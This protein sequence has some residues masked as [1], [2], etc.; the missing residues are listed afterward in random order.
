M[1]IIN[2]ITTEDGDILQIKPEV[3]IVGLISLYNFVDTTVGESETDYYSKEFRYSVNGGITF[4]SWL[5]L[6]TINIS[7]VDIK[8]QDQFVIEY[9]YTHIGG[10]PS[11]NLE[12]D[13][14]LVSSDIEDLDYP[15][16]GTTFF[17]DFFVVNDINVYGWALN[18][19]EK[20]Y[21]YGILPKYMTRGEQ[22]DNVLEDQDFLSFWNSLTHYFAIIVYY[23]RQFRDITQHPNI[24]E[25][26]LQNRGVEAGNLE[27]S[28]LVEL[29]NDYMQQFT[30]RGT[31]Q[32]VEIGT[33]NGEFLRMIEFVFPEEFIL[34]QLQNFEIGWCVGKSSPCWNNTE[35]IVNIIKGYEYTDGVMDLSKYPLVNSA[36]VSIVG[37]DMSIQ[38][39][40]NAN[41]AGVD[42][43]SDNAKKIV[44]NKNLDY[45]ISFFCKLDVANTPLTFG[46]RSY[47]ANGNE[48]S[49]L[50]AVN[51][52][53][54]NT[55]FSAQVLKVV[56]HYY[57]VRGIIYNQNKTNDS[58][59]VFVPNGHHLRFN[60]ATA[61]KY[62]VPTI[63][64]DNSSTS[65]YPNGFKL[66]SIVVRPLKVPFTRGQLG[67]KNVVLSYLV[68]N[69]KIYSTDKM[70]SLMKSQLL[71]AN[72]FLKVNYIYE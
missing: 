22:S 65:V 32:I 64:L 12:F 6:S 50:N 59:A 3:P 43:D 57:W 21:L 17:K 7:N 5:S 38:N 45:E 28:Q 19:L 34:A 27:V 54:S 53:A 41:F 25:L 55:F 56:G 9:R 20:L 13:D 39:V 30:D 23:A 48:I 1:A 71:P 24:V 35:N 46:V 51:G 62:I 18:V 66:N 68:N 26:F 10:S 15:I 31:N 47:D 2:N 44:V 72:T 63:L 36:K 16:Y 33:V 60:S 61:V 40:A 69:N 11:V 42:F 4:S 67:I 14:I 8:K 37:T 29:F 49:L 52:V 58:G 70:E